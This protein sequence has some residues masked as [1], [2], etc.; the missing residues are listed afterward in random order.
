MNKYSLGFISDKKIFE[1]VKQTVDKYRFIIDL[2]K[3]KENIVDP[4]KM[5]FDSKVYQRSI[6]QVIE[7]EVMRQLDKSN[8]NHIGYFHQNIFKILND[9]WTVPEKRFD[10]V[11]EAEHFYVEMKNKHNTMNSSSSQKT[12]TRMSAQL[13]KT[14][15]A[16]CFLVEVI[17]KKSQNAPWTISLDGERFSSERIRRVSIDQF[18]TFVTKDPLAFYKLCVALPKIIEDVVQ[19]YQGSALITNTVLVELK[20]LSNLSNQSLLNTIYNL[21]FKSY[22]G[23]NHE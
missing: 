15:K 9:N 14:P 11:N 3:F 21:S 20:D 16:T 18:Y 8:T 5:T 13:A 17:S 1:H 6:E 10:V 7:D 23:F 2:K 22:Q 19:T 12:Y 4:I